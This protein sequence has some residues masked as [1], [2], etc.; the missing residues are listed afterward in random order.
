MNSC[1]R[2]PRSSNSRIDFGHRRPDCYESALHT[3]LGDRSLRA[4]L[5]GS[6]IRSHVEGLRGGGRGLKLVG[7]GLSKYARSA[8]FSRYAGAEKDGMHDDT[9]CR[10]GFAA[11]RSFRIRFAVSRGFL[12]I[13]SERCSARAGGCKVVTTYRLRLSMIGLSNPD[14]ARARRKDRA[15]RPREA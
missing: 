1:P 8:L 11:E 6:A 12:C 13:N 7:S 3:S 2:G 5:C 10:L 14:G 4:F 15:V 9:S